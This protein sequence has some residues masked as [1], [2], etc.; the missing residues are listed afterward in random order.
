MACC[1]KLMCP[2]CFQK[3]MQTKGME[4]PNCAVVRPPSNNK[5]YVA[6]VRKN[7]DE[8]E[9][10]WALAL[11]ADLYLFGHPDVEEEKDFVKGKK[12]YKYLW[13]ENGN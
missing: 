12:K 4:C 5:A 1:A 13:G 10:G 2:G 8:N 9:Y 11:M 3:D 7:A 6:L